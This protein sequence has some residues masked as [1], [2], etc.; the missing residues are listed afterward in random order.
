MATLF[1]ATDY[2]PAFAEVLSQDRRR[3]LSGGVP[4]AE[5]QRTLSRLT[6]DAAFAH[7]S[8][9]DPEAADCCLAAC[10][11]LVDDLARSHVISQSIGSAEGS[12]WH[13]VMHR[14]EGDFGNAKYWFRQVGKHPGASQ[15]AERHGG[16][17]HAGFVDACQRA[18]SRG[19]GLEDCLDRQQSEWECLF[20]WCYAKAVRA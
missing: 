16:W 1:D 18:V 19:E 20:D 12:W 7:T 13:G 3:P 2:G 6:R 15:L 5:D 11:L 14:R 8:V 17:E 4:G 9:F 10:W